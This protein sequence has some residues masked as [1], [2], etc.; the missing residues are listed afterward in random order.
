[1]AENQIW[2]IVLCTLLTSKQSSALEDISICF[3]HESCAASEPMPPDEKICRVR[4][5]ATATREIARRNGRATLAECTE[6]VRSAAA[7]KGHHGGVRGRG[8]A[9][10]AYSSWKKDGGAFVRRT[11]DKGAVGDAREVIIPRY[12]RSCV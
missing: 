2:S 1:M 5:E 12:G 7:Q 9:Y 8:C 11:D 3:S 10:Y 6:D 4:G